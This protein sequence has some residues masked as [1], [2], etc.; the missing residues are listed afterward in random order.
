ML[1]AELATMGIGAIY[2]PI[3]AGYAADQL[4]ALVAHAEPAA[5]LLAGASQLEQVGV[6]RSART[7][8]TFDPLP[9]GMTAR[10]APATSHLAFADAVRRGRSIDG[11]IAEWLATAAAI[12]PGK[13]ALMMYT[14]GTSGPLKGVLLSHDNIL[15]QQ[16]ALSAIWDV[17]P[18]DRFLSYLPWHHSFG[19]IFEK[20][21][22]LYHGAALCIDESLGKDFAELLR[23]WKDVQPTIYFSVPKIYQ[24]LVVHAQA[25]PDDEGQI[26]RRGCASSSRPPL[27]CRPPFRPSSRRG[28]P[29]L[30]GGAFTGDIAVL[31]LTDFNEPRT[32]PGMIGYPIPDQHL[33]CTRR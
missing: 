14:S 25:H 11:S 28:I 23:N 27:R 3:F 15:S 18:D 30:E 16:R 6:P 9:P 17:T 7:V 32:I 31:H 20:Y 22:A 12:D 29:V 4:Q 19:G 2:T 1:V 26:F 5:L 10:A 24:Q 8:V 13:P 21:T 33:H